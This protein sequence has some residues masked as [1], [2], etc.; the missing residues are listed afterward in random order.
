V[1]Q[2]RPPVVEFRSASSGSVGMSGVCMCK[3]SNRS[4]RR[5]S[6]TLAP[7]RQP[8][9]ARPIELPDRSGTDMPTRMTPFSAS[10]ARWR[11]GL[12]ASAGTDAK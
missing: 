5:I 2:V 11:S 9:D 6:R 7:S 1:Q 3:T 10:C 12:R 8:V 4:L